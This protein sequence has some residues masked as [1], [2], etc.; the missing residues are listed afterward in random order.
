[1]PSTSLTQI[2]R[3]KNDYFEPNTYE[4]ASEAE[5]GKMSED[6]RISQAPY[7]PKIQVWARSDGPYTL[8]VGHQWFHCDDLVINGTEYRQKSKKSS[9]QSTSSGNTNSNSNQSVY[10]P[11]RSKRP[12]AARSQSYNRTRPE[13][14][15]DVTS[16]V[17][18]VSPSPPTVSPQSSST[19]TDKLAAPTQYQPQALPTPKEQA[20]RRRHRRH[21]RDGEPPRTSDRERR[22]SGAAMADQ[23]S[24][25][26]RESYGALVKYQAPPPAEAAQNQADRE[27]Q[28]VTRPMRP[29][30][31]RR[32]SSRN[33]SYQIPVRKPGKKNVRFAPLPN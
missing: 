15:Q 23:P 8:R 2:P 13:K 5:H 31:M 26:P 22:D 28:K 14:K 4:S 12:Q 10:P 1:M 30:P 20:E 18:P 3:E 29:G 21:H 19:S 7:L 24:S 11:Q 9:S 25:S 33:S 17:V 6:Q 27:R 16:T 32:G